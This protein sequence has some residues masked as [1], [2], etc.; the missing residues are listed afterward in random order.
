MIRKLLFITL[1]VGLPGL[2]LAS[3]KCGNNAYANE[4]ETTSEIKMKCGTPMDT[5]NLGD[6]D[7]RGK[8]VHLE[9][10]T[11]KPGYGSFYQIFEFQNGIL[12]SVKQGARVH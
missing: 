10:W 11:Y 9:R 12:V 4:G 3:H 7:I 1:L 2:T 8:R 5:E 6:V